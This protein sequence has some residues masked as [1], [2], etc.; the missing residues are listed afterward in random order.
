MNLEEQKKLLE[1]IFNYKKHIEEDHIN[2]VVDFETQIADAIKNKLKIRESDTEEKVTIDDIFEWC[3]KNDLEPMQL[4][5]YIAKK[6]EDIG[7]I[8]HNGQTIQFSKTRKIMD[9][10]KKN[11]INHEDLDDINN[12]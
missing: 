6:I 2:N 7:D 12:F 8:H 3:S 10:I 5:D 9:Q 11:F 4:V 1:T